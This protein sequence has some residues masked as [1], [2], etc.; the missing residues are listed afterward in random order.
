MHAVGA[1]DACAYGMGGV[2][3]LG[4][5]GSPPIV[6]RARF[7]DHIRR[8]VVSDANPK[9]TVTNSDLELAATIAQHDVTAAHHLPTPG[10]IFTATDNTPAL[11]W[12]RKGSTTTTGPAAYLLRIQALHQRRHAY[13]TQLAHITGEANTMA[14]DASQRWDLDDSAFL[15]HFALSF[16]QATPWT[17]HRLPP[18]M[19]SSLVSALRM[20]EPDLGSYLPPGT[21][22]TEPGRSGPT[23]ARSYTSIPFCRPST[24][25]SPSS[26]SMRT[27]CATGPLPAVVN[28]SGLQQLIPPS[29]TWGRRVPYWGLRTLA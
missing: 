7:L 15:T 1:C 5:T 14:D 20:K 21:Q 4:R 27:R 11:A 13:T 17:M 24:I 6:W 3:F 28:P 2:V 10:C 12:Q 18:A 16:P 25:L 22:P 19:L 29:A 8:Q 23:S 26:R 9:G